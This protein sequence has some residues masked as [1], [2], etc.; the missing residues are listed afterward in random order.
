M[1][2]PS[3]ISKY[4][5]GL[6]IT[7]CGCPIRAGYFVYQGNEFWDTD[8]HG[9]IG[10]VDKLMSGFHKEICFNDIPIRHLVHLE[11][12]TELINESDKEKINLW[13]LIQGM[14]I[15]KIGSYL[16]DYDRMVNREL[17][18]MEEQKIIVQKEIQRLKKYLENYNQMVNQKI[19]SM[20]EEKVKS[21]KEL[22]KN[23][24]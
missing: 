4:P 8:V 21:Q 6:T 17:K 3:F 2:F 19:Q 5:N 22:Q 12:R 1:A 14:N 15:Q 18:L 11:K 9:E 24:S 23:L 16:K 7:K 20:E 13:C 10:G